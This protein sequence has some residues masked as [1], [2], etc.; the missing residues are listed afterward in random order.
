MSAAVT[1][2]DRD[3]RSKLSGLEGASSNTFKR[4]AQLAAGFLSARALFGFVSGAM[5]EFSRLEEGNNKLKYTYTDL[6]CNRD[7]LWSRSLG[8]EFVVISAPAFC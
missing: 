1:L 6:W 8:A 4:I 7:F 3:Y 5:S 2:D